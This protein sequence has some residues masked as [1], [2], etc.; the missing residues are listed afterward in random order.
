MIDGLYLMIAGMGT[1]FAFLI[2]MVLALN[3]SGWYF[4]RRDAR[5]AKKAE[6]ES[7]PGAVKP[8]S[9]KGVSV[10]ANV[11]ETSGGSAQS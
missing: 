2:L 8:T 5:L 4:Q 9:N 11:V 7:N 10:G 3:A 6:L 1:V